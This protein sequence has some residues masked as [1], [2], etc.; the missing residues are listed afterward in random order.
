M[1]AAEKIV[2]DLA[3]V[4][5]VRSESAVFVRMDGNLAVIN[6][7]PSTIQVPCVG[8]Y[9]PVTGMPVRVDWINGS[10]TV[11]G[12]VRP[13][14]P[15]GVVTGP[16]S[17]K[18]TV[19]VDGQEYTL[20]Y[21][22]GYTPQVGHTVEINWSTGIIQGRVT[23]ADNPE[24]PGESGG[25]KT[26]FDVTVRAA[27]SGRYQG[28][29]WG[30]DPW[31]SDS[32]VGIWTYEGRVRDA[33]GAGSIA[34]IDIYLPLTQELGNCAI[35][36]HEHAAIPSGDPGIHSSVTLPLGGRAGWV[37]LPVNFGGHL[38]AG[39]RGIGVLAPG[40]GGYNKWL[41]TASDG[42]SG[43]LRITGVR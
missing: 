1:T 10:P 37:R 16:G 31:A 5:T 3:A 2:R 39:G 33:V 12:Q 36:V 42:M 18:A 20:F 19:R 22:D 11:V 29:W 13:L 23:G 41:G 4:D 25:A 21:R 38:A 43:A 15:L 27:D 14:N 28:N 30:N 32:N 40:A 24:A 6:I 17:P 7:G 26:P 9:P 8:F 35:G 34:T